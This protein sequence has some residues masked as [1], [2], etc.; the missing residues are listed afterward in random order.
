MFNKAVGQDLSN[1]SIISVPSFDG[2][3]VAT[4]RTMYDKSDPPKAIGRGWILERINGNKLETISIDAKDDIA[5][6]SVQL[7]Y[8]KMPDSEDIKNED[9]IDGDYVFDP[10]TGQNKKVGA[11]TVLKNDG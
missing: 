11:G 4:L 6:L 3:L 8:G 1:P 2:K 10:I 7:G 9:E 5:K